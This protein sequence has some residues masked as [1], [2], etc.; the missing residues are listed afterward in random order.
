MLY[1]IIGTVLAGGGLLWLFS[2]PREGNMR[3]VGGRRIKT[4][5]AWLLIRLGSHKREDKLGLEYSNVRVPPLPGTDIENYNDSF[6]FQ[7]SD[8]EGSLFMTRIGFRKGGREAEVWLWMV[9]EGKKYVIDRDLVEL[10]PEDQAT[11]SAGGIT[12][13][14]LDREKSTWRIT[15]EGKLNGGKVEC[16]VD[17]TF[18]PRSEIYH[19]G[20]HMSPWSFAKA[21]SEMKWSREY[22][23]RLRSENQT[24]IEQGGVLQGQVVV[25][26]KKVSLDLP[27]IRDHSWGKRDWTYINRYIWNILSFQHDIMINNE[28]YRYLVYTTVDYGSSFRHLVTGWIGGENSVLPIVEAS[29]MS[30]LGVDGTIPEFFLTRFRARGGPVMQIKYRRS[31]I[32]HPWITQQGGF[33]IN[34]A[35]CRCRV[36]E[37][38]GSGM[39]E[40]GFALNRGYNRPADSE[41]SQ[42][43]EVPYRSD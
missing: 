23:N 37:A 5:L 29:D 12:Y 25:N 20:I 6:V 33:E 40:F 13:T 31:R 16:S 39:S 14:C 28:A 35:Q 11:I 10:D 18:T 2:T 34:E 7:G 38:R 41:K 24:R 1:W 17:L 27:G 19:S 15:C 36:G 32:E 26:G 42:G 3:P 43:K 4:I 22:F 8:R 30:A 9:L 21:M